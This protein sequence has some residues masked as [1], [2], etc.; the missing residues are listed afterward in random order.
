MKPRIKGGRYEFMDVYQECPVLS[1]PGFKLTRTC[2][3]DASDLLLCYSDDRSAP[4]FNSDNC[5]GDDFRYHTIER[6]LQAIDF[7]EFSYK[8]RYFVRWSIRRHGEDPAI[9]TVEMFRRTAD[10]DYN[11]V[12][13]LR[14]DLRSADER[15]EVLDELLQL[16]CRE[17]F[18]MFS[19]SRILIKAPIFADTRRR[20]V[21]RAGGMPCQ[22]PF[23]GYSDYFFFSEDE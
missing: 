4:R 8:N 7:W 9:G 1:G 13:V 3:S 11:G 15:P 14:V 21:L 2:R 22:S 20:A 17:F 5:H 10:D 6:M 19:V 18:A 12:G 23:I 16:A